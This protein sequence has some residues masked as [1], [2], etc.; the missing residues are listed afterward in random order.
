MLDANPAALRVLHARG[1]RES[2]GASNTVVRLVS[3]TENSLVARNQLEVEFPATRF[4]LNFIYSLANGGVPQGSADVM[5]GA[6]SCA[7]DRCYGPA[8]INWRADL[9]S[10][11]VGVKIGVIDTAVDETHPALGWRKLNVHQASPK[12]TRAT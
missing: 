8:L 10:C 12:V 4:G 9:A 11:A 7:P 2:P 6:R 1:W 3:E 5:A